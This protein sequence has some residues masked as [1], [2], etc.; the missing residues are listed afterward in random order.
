MSRVTVEDHPEAQRYELSAE[1]ERIG[2]VRYRI[3]GEVIALLHAEVEP[4]REGQGWGSRLVAGTLDDARA[5]GLTVHPVCPFV[6]AFIRRHPR[7][8]DLLA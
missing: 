3:T 1:G 6:V 8:Q 5:R 7:Y 4:A 2:F